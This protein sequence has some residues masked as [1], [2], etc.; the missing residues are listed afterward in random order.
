MLEADVT[1]PGIRWNDITAAAPALRSDR[2]ALG[3]D[4]TGSLAVRMDSNASSAGRLIVEMNL[5]RTELH[6]VGVA[7]K[8]PGDR[9]MVRLGGEFDGGE[10][11]ISEGEVLLRD[12]LMSLQGSLA[13][14]H[15]DL[16]LQGRNTGL[17][18]VRAIV[19]SHI[20]RDL[21]DLAVTGLG[22]MDARFAANGSALEIDA[23]VSAFDASMALR[24]I[25][26]KPQGEHFEL[27]ATLAKSPESTRIDRLSIE[28]G[29]TRM[30][31][32]GGISAAGELAGALG[33][34]IDVEPFLANAPGLARTKTGA[35]RNSDAL[36]AIQD[37][38]GFAEI[39]WRVSGTPATPDLKLDMDKMP[40][41]SIA[42]IVSRQLGQFT[43]IFL[44]PV[45][46]GANM[47]R[48]LAVGSDG[49]ER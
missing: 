16:H 29:R 6:F 30:E 36:L 5:D 32:A 1:F 35:Y 19:A 2:F 48:S 42:S 25:W 26:K 15:Y 47:L 49:E 24:D 22:N 45:T 31:F 27:N 12:T 28:Q 7:R 43:G 44:S 9:C 37:D 23:S 40:K 33:A 46:F 38:S 3:G 18:G 41:H 8:A 14:S 21:G 4:A 11:E 20:W 39:H 10:L 13:A 17:D 34:W